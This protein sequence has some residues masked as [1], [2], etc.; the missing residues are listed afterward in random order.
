MKRILILLAGV[1]LFACS[2]KGDGFTI[3]G[4][5]SG[6][7]GDGVE[8]YLTNTS[9][10]VPIRDTVIAKDGKFTFTGVVT[11]PEFYIISIEDVEGS[12]QFFLANEELTITI[13]DGDLNGAEITG[14]ESYTLVSNF[15]KEVNDVTEEYEM[16]KLVSEFYNPNTTDERRG[17]IMQINNKVQSIVNEIET[18][19]LADNPTSFYAVTKMIENVEAAP[20]AEMEAKIAQFDALPQ[21]AQNRFLQ[22]VKEAVAVLKNLEPG[23]EAPDFTLPTPEGEELSL[24]DVYKEHKLTMIDFWAGWCGPCRQFNPTLVELYNKYKDH[25]FGIIGVSLDSD[26]AVWKGAIEDDNLT[27][28]QVSDLKYWQSAPAAAYYIRSIPANCFVDGEG[29]II[30]RKVNRGE[31]EEFIKEHLG[32]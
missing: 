2:P 25:G 13:E 18:K 9:R 11:T 21:F 14:G 7:G 29:K 32:L 20:I 15:V 8:V 12:R 28:P 23:M 5:I 19:F 22:D 1:M 6:E 26:E 30:Q 27:W 10:A 3:S 24:S 31:I 16:Q 4:T 17:E